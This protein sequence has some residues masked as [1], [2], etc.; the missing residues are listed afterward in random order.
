M[1]TACGSRLVWAT[2]LRDDF[3][4][5]DAEPEDVLQAIRV[6][7]C[8]G[9]SLVVPVAARAARL[10]LPGPAARP[11]HGGPAELGSS[12]RALRGAI[13]AREHDLATLPA[14]GTALRAGDD[15]PRA[16][17]KARYAKREHEVRMVRSRQRA[18][19]ASNALKSRRL[20]LRWWMCCT[21][22]ACGHFV[23]A[24]MLLCIVAA[25]AANLDVQ[26]PAES[27]GPSSRPPPVP[28]WFVALLCAVAMAGM[29]GTLL[30][31]IV[32]RALGARQSSICRGQISVDEALFPMA[33]LAG[34]L[35]GCSGSRCLILIQRA[36]AAVT[37]L[38]IAVGPVLL[39]VAIADAAAGAPR[40]L[41]VAAVPLYLAGCLLPLSVCKAGDGGCRPESS[42]ACAGLTICVVMPLAAVL[43]M[44]T[45]VADGLVQLDAWVV[46]MP[47]FVMDAIV[48]IASCCACAVSTTDLIRQGRR[49]CRDFLQV[50][51]GPLLLMLLFL[52]TV[53][54][55]EVLS[56]L[57]IDGV[58]SPSWGA[59]S[60]TVFVLLL[61]LVALCV[62]AGVDAG[63][64]M[65]RSEPY[66]R[67]Q[68]EN[69]LEQVA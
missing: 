20:C 33:P 12:A 49:R 50:M 35:W 51:C 41:S 27:A 55:L 48:I 24:I 68:A 54:A 46:A 58:Y 42:A 19:E 60:A 1:D 43:A 3:L 9:A 45:G 59:I 37:V 66:R 7:S 65:H 53:V 39:L 2:L 38:S 56:V 52:G 14:A 63:R 61:P 64:R 40:W 34:F 8:A 44:A 62:L 28:W 22:Q 69:R 23:P 18:V 17:Y 29:L 32:A 10:Q 30:L 4:L 36:W 6:A 15:D 11:R 26:L 13:A 47:L 16:M 21:Q 67:F 57:R 5:A 25:V 31:N